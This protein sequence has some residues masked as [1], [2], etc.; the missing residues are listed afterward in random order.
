MRRDSIFFRLFQQFPMLLFELL[1]D[2]PE[3]ADRYR[4]DSVAVKETKF[5]IDGVFLPPA[6]RKGIVYFCEVQFQ[7]DQKLY[8]R[9]WSESSRYFYQTRNRFSD[10]QAVVIYPRRSM[11]QKNLHPHRSLLNGGQLHRIYL[12]E[13]GDIEAL[14]L[15]LAAMALT[16]KTKKAMP[17]VAKG[18]VERAQQEVANP[19]EKRAIMDMVS[20]IVV[21]EF[22]NLTRQEVDK[23]LGIRLEETRVYRD[24]KEEGLEEGLE[25]ARQQNLDRQRSLTLRQLTRY[26]GKIPKKVKSRIDCLS[27][28]DLE[29]LGDAFLDFESIADL[30]AWLDANS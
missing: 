15:G 16:T 9:L 1:D 14:P 23:M 28:D 10:W 17:K 7:P 30:E 29:G 5:E 6:R 25:R 22:T 27:L 20:T 26:V 12:E 11:E 3:N 2:P 13:L 18:L 8:E 19:E 4:F 21:H 24:A